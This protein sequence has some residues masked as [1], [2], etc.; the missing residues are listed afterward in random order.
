MP[1]RTHQPPHTF[2]YIKCTMPGCTNDAEM[3]CN[4]CNEIVCGSC[5][6]GDHEWTDH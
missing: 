5:F 1:D 4:R 2:S 6:N 3:I